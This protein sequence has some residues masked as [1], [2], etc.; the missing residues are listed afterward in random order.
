MDSVLQLTIYR[1]LVLD[2]LIVFG[3]SHSVLVTNLGMLDHLKEIDESQKSE[4]IGM[5]SIYNMQYTF[6]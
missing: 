5:W 4:L 3:N 6:L 2:L 1:Q